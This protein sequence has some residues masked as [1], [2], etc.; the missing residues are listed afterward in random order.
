MAESVAQ[1]S[2]WFFGAARLIWPI[3]RGKS[4]DAITA[5]RYAA[6]FSSG[7]RKA[8]PSRRVGGK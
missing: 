3:Y 5:S 1:T 2:D 4:G 6:G 8:P 7:L